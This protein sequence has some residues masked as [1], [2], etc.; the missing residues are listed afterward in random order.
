VVQ[1]TSQVALNL[2]F[3]TVLQEGNGYVGGYLVTNQWGRPLEFRLSTI[4]QP[5]RVQQILYGQTLSPYI[6]S[7]LIGKALV[8]KTSLAPSLIVTDSQIVL[9]L[10]L[11]TDLPVAWL[12]P[13]ETGGPSSSGLCPIDSCPWPLYRHPHFQ[14][15][16][17]QIRALVERLDG[18]LDLAEPF[19][20][21]REAICEARKIGVTKSA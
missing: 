16:L 12:G 20:R 3:L 19:G 14:G 9:D 2:G 6:C 10:R 17:A 15:D 21:V 18:V 5:N 8:E 11:H 4:V 7:D 13:R 1:T